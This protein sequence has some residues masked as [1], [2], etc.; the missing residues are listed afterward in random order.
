MTSSTSTRLDLRPDLALT[1]H[2]SGHCAPVLL[3]HG[4]PGP[5]SL[6]PLA[7]HLATGHRVLLPTHP[8]WDDTPRPDTLATVG[9]L[10]E[11]YLELLRRLGT[12]PVTVL[13]TSFGGWVATEVA[14]RDTDR[15]VER[16]VLIDAIGPLVPGH[17]VT[18][19]SPGPGPGTGPGPGSGPG[20]G[21]SPAAMAA[22]RSYSGPQL[23]DPGLLARLGAVTAP[24][25]V[26]WGED[27]P[28]VSPDYG[29]AYAAAFPHARFQT[30]PLAGHLPTREQPGAVRAAIDAFLTA[31]T[32]QTS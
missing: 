5:G 25:L 24:V 9:D 3:L 29:R 1:L 28:V 8:G 26:L 16:L 27:D 30:I 12:G 10:A 15:T 21:P 4:G 6:T 19:P 2:Q 22:L 18:A 23:H 31:P 17:P 14:L 32:P 20:P 13:G 7:E 11:A